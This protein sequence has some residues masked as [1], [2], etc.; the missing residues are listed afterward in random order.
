MPGTIRKCHSPFHSPD[1]AGWLKTVD[2]Y[3]TGGNNSIQ[4]ANTGLTIDTVLQSLNDNPDRRFIYV[5]QAFFERWL[6]EASDQQLTDMKAA[7]ASG[8]MT[9]INGGYCM[10]DEAAPSYVDMIDQTQLGH[11]IIQ[12]TFGPSIV[13]QVT[14][15]ID[16]FGKTAAGGGGLR[17]RAACM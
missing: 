13:P 6:E 17:A 1:D 9:F 14:W 4:Y 11:R 5:E 8:A 2:E 16:P 7:V 10:H 12:E 3:A 15:Q